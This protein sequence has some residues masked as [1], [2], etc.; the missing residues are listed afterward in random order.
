M[1][2][3]QTGLGRRTVQSSEGSHPAGWGYIRVRSAPIRRH[4]K[5]PD[6]NFDKFLRDFQD[7]VS[8]RPMIEQ[9]FPAGTA[10]RDNG[11]LAIGFLGFWMANRDDGFDCAVAFQQCAADS[12]RFGAHRH[13]SDGRAEMNAR[14]NAAIVAANRSGHHMPERLIVA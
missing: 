11:E 10:G 2:K 13:A 12:D 7:Y 1:P 4:E 6:R 3:P 8:V 14:P 9:E 5:G